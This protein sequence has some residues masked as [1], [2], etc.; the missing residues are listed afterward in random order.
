MQNKIES[1]PSDGVSPDQTAP[2]PPA[3]ILEP[4]MMELYGDH[5]LT[6]PQIQSGCRPDEWPSHPA[7]IAPNPSSEGGVA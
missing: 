5:I 7:A 2:K 1:K 3:L 4:P 6:P